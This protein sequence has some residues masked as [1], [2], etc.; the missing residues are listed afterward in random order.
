MQ[1]K[2]AVLVVFWGECS[3]ETG[4]AVDVLEEPAIS[5]VREVQALT[6]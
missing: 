1:F 5:S 4:C 3:C 2:W 6:F